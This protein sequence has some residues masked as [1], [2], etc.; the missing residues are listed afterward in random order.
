MTTP[1]PLPEPVDTILEEIH[2]TRRMLL[3]E[4]GGIAGLAAFL[5]QQEANAGQVV[6]APDS[7]HGTDRPTPR[8]RKPRDT[9][10]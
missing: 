9:K 7:F 8:S 10:G 6:R 3:E 1:N 4:H 5:R 2:Q